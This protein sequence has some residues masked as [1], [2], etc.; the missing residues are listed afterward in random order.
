[1]SDIAVKVEHLSK[2]YRLDSEL[3]R[4]VGRFVPGFTPVEQE[5]VQALQDISL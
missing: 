3:R 2:N 4:I 1:M 5:T